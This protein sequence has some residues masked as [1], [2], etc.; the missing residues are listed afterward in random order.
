MKL[1]TQPHDELGSAQLVLNSPAPRV[2]RCYTAP[3]T[4]AHRS[5][6]PS[7]PHLGLVAGT[8]ETL[9]LLT[10]GVRTRAEAMQRSMVASAGGLAKGAGTQAVQRHTHAALARQSCP[11]LVIQWLCF[12]TAF[13]QHC[14]VPGP[15]HHS[16]VPPC[17][18]PMLLLHAAGMNEKVAKTLGAIDP[19]LGAIY[20]SSTDGINSLLRDIASS[21]QDAVSRYL[22]ASTN[23]VVRTFAAHHAC[24]NPALNG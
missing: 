18:C 7:Y 1:L 6:T 10:L 21:Q 9:D 20:N 17:C 16:C 4:H 22:K 19:R 3:Q 14:M 2:C 11:S 13:S 15:C 24:V 5:H 23:R 12:V 8:R